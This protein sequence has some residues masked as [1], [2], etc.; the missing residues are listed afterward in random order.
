[1]AP[2]AP[3]SPAW[4]LIYKGLSSIFFLGYIPLAPGTWGSA[5]AVGFV[6]LLK[7]QAPE[8]LAASNVV[9]HWVFLALFTMMAILIANR[10]QQAMGVDNPDPGPVVIDEFLGQLI[11]FFMIPITFRTLILGFFL[12]RFFDIVKP[13]PVHK[14][15]EID[16]GAGI[17]MDDVAAGVMA[18]ISMFAIIAAFRVVSAALNS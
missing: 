9:Y 11:T 17:V 18:N 13:Y 4:K 7:F 6:V 10:A 16:E 3:L 15:E 2:K 8:L 5:A 14:M 12:F 1:M